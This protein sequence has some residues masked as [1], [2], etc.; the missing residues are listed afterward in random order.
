MAIEQINLGTVVQ[1]GADGDV[2]R[3]A[4]TKVN[5]NFADLESRKVEKVAG[6]QLSTEDYTSAEKM[7]LAGIESGAQVN[8]VTSVA[9]KTGAITLAKGDVGLGNVDN[10][11]D[12]N[13]PVSTAQQAALDGKLD[14][15]ANAV[16]ATKLQ[17]ARTIT[18]TGDVTGSANFDGSGNVSINTQVADDSHTHSLGN[19]GLGNA[20]TA[21]V[22]TSLTDTTTG[23]LMAVGAFG[24][25]SSAVVLSEVNLNDDRPTGFYY[26]N[27][28]TNRPR[29]ENGWL[30][31]EDL[32]NAGY[33]SQTYKTISGCVFHRT[34]NAGSWTTWVELFNTGNIL[35][36]VSQSGGVPTG[37]IIESGSNA[38]GEY[39]KFA[40]GTLICHHTGAPSLLN[41]YNIGFIWS[42]PSAFI[43]PPSVSFNALSAD[44]MVSK[45]A[46]PMVYWNPS[47]GNWICSLLNTSGSFVASDAP[48]YFY[49]VAIGR[50]Y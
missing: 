25:G 24:L 7:K 35:G 38:N 33:A 29:T 45:I 21:T 39:V 9:G 46:Q 36:T 10:T 42:L 27:S 40:D 30:I 22:Q 12:A 47:A 49:M 8:T 5:A 32:S 23:R 43:T 31:H 17:T 15:T 41:P 34:Q 28:V 18:L 3:V 1:D 44:V 4:F 19:L 13:K 2:A 26:C 37:A 20:A 14:A 11:S 6:K 50:W 48:S 16:S